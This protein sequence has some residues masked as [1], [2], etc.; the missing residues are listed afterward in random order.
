MD[1]LTILEKQQMKGF[2]LE[3]GFEGRKSSGGWKKRL[4]AVAAVILIGIPAF[5]VAFPAIA[6]NIPIIGSIFER[7]ELHDW[8]RLTELYEFASEVGVS[9]EDD[10]I[11]I[12][13]NEVFFDGRRVYLSYVIEADRDLGE[14][15]ALA[16][17]EIG[18]M[19]DGEHVSGGFGIGHAERL[20][21]NIY[22]GVTS[23]TSGKLPSDIYNVEI[24]LYISQLYRGEGD[25]IASGNWNF[26]FPVEVVDHKMFEVNQTVYY[27]GFEVTIYE[28][29]LSLTTTYFYFST[30][31]PMAMYMTDGNEFSADIEWEISDDLGY[32]YELFGGVMETGDERFVEGMWELGGIDPNASSLIITPVGIIVEWNYDDER[33]YVGTVYERIDL[34]AIIIDLP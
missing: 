22:V 31:T 13:I 5:G 29:M 24:F 10:G 12:T 33:D 18:L 7:E 3:Q 11:A 30:S 25:P 28:L 34:P 23:F 2:I 32:V 21:G 1:Q 20:E 8:P 4:I 16:E 27:E 17:G 6:A 19:I 15:I 9:V 26:R 14:W